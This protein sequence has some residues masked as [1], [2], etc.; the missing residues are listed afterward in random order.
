MTIIKHFITFIDLFEKKLNKHKNHFD[1]SATFGTSVRSIGSGAAF[2][3]HQAM[4]ARHKS[5][6]DIHAKFTA[7][8]ASIGRFV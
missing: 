2:I 6:G 1:R 4:S 7:F 5:G 8:D 3:T